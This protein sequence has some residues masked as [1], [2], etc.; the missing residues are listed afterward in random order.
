MESK[1]TVMTDINYLNLK[2]MRNMYYNNEFDINPL[3]KY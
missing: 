1:Y 2:V 3:R